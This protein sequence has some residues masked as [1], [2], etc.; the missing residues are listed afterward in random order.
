MFQDRK[1]WGKERS[2]TGKNGG[3]TQGKWRNRYHGHQLHH[4]LDS[5]ERLAGLEVQ[6]LSA[7]KEDSTL[8]DIDAIGGQ[9]FF[10]V[11]LGVSASKC[12]ALGALEGEG[13]VGHEPS[14]EKAAFDN[15]NGDVTLGQ[16]EHVHTLR[17]PPFIGAATAPRWA[18][19]PPQGLVRTWRR[20]R[21]EAA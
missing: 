6:D 8:V 13:W 5:R 3:N 9:A 18:F 7:D 14:F 17:I 19:G 21:T 12:R 2:R 4:G 16:C 10:C 20:N 15:E 11:Q 1:E